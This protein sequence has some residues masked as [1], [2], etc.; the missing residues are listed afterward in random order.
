MPLLKS[1]AYYAEKHKHV[2]MEMAKNIAGLS[3]AVKAKVGSVIYLDNHTLSMGLNG[4]PS[5][6][7]TEVCEYHDQDH[8]TTC[9]TVI[10]AEK[11]AI[12]KITD[13]GLLK[14]AI[15]FV[16][17]CPCL[18]CSRLIQEVGIQKVYYSDEYRSKEGIEYLQQHSI[19]CVKI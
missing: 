15:L 4:Q 5:G 1:P 12:D 3:K 13:E 2:Y 16:T 17:L 19:E 6:Y 14:G 7:H 18:R 11:A 8:L 10:H 9:N